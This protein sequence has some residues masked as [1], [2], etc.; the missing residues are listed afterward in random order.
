MGSKVSLQ[1]IELPSR[2]IERAFKINIRPSLPPPAASSLKI[3][4]SENDDE[5]ISIL[6]KEILR[7]PNIFLSSFFMFKILSYLYSGYK[8]HQIWLN[9]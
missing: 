7:E 2:H 8:I 3:L 6:A 5:L 4:P 9:F 1:N